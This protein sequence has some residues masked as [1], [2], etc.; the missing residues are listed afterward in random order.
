MED[1]GPALTTPSAAEHFLEFALQFDSILILIEDQETIEI[2]INVTKEFIESTMTPNAE[3]A[4]V[5]ISL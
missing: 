4:N 5:S 1:Q 3:T 2:F